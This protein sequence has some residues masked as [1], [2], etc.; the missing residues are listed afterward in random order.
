M[1]Q[2]PPHAG[3][4]G[5]HTLLVVD[6]EELVRRLLVSMLERSGYRV[7]QASDGEEAIRVFRDH[8]T[9]VSAVILDQTMPT[10]KGTDVLDRLRE[11]GF[12]VPVLIATGLASETVVARVSASPP[13]AVLEKPF[14][15]D[16]L[17]RAVES[18]LGVS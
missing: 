15:K 4:P 8:H 18:L 11:D 5:A 9:E 3:S 6:D 12:D 10:L 7:L 13:A 17:H 2:P 16:G 1:A 14:R